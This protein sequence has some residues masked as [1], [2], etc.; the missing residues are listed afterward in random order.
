M[1]SL[2]I[3]LKIYRQIRWLI[4]IGLIFL[5]LNLSIRHWMTPQFL[6]QDDFVAYWSAGH[7]LILGGNPYNSSELL[8]VEREKAWRPWEEAL[9]LWNPPWTLVLLLPFGFL[10]YSAARVLW[11]FLQIVTVAWSAHILWALYGG[12]FRK[13]LIAWLLAFSYVPTLVMIRYG[14][15]AM[16]ILLGLS[17]FL[18]FAQR[19]RWTAAGVAL[20]LTT[21]KPQVIYLILVAAGLWMIR[22]R[23]WRFGFGWISPIVLAT[24]LVALINPAIL[25]AYLQTM[26]EESPARLATFTLGAWLRLSLGIE[27]EIVQ[28]FP[29]LLGLAGTLWY[30][31][32]HLQ[33][34]WSRQLPRL[35]MFSLITMPYGWLYDYTVALIAILPSVLTIPKQPSRTFRWAAYGCYIFLNIMPVFSV[36]QFQYAWIGVVQWIWYEWVSRMTGQRYVQ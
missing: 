15:S 12:P 16:W 28:F 9:M 6:Y 8:R 3:L 21:I 10:P 2:T 36:H 22:N 24:A 4:L 13:S 27:S 35:T 33:W 30:H 7:L 20:S 23:N 5:L 19:R 34:N 17:G 29:V 1:K 11:F 14:Q 18:Y 32:Y 25:Y 26:R 31:H